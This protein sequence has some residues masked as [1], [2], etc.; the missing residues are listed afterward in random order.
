M[1]T[2]LPRRTFLGLAAAVP[3][4][5]VAAATAARPAFLACGRELATAADF[6]FALSADGDIVWRTKLPGRGHGFARNGETAIVFGRRPGAFAAMLGLARGEVRAWLHPAP[7]HVFAGHGVF[8]AGGRLLAI[9]EYAHADAAGAVSLRETA[10]GF[11][12]LARWPTHGIDPHEMILA[13]GHLVVANGGIP[14]GFQP[15]RD[16][17]DLCRPSLARLDPHDGRLVDL[18]EPPPAL[19]RV[20]LRHLALSGGIIAIA[21]Q[22]QGRAA[23]DLPVLVEARARGLVHHAADGLHG[24][25]GSIAAGPGGLCLTG[26]R[27]NRAL[28]LDPA[29]RAT[30]IEL[31]DVC[32]V[33]PDGAGFLLSGGAGDIDW[34]DGRARRHADVAFD[35]HMLALAA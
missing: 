34:T 7:G 33:A 25:A 26:P 24:Y 8:L 13:G 31:R 2:D 3:F 4:A 21:G 12:E 29:G 11:R 16:D 1:A 35:N 20:S 9:V 22:D 19:R 30:C 6:A 10:P 5:R 15:R 23:G 18:A 27:A 28:V 17:P 14:Q 32:G